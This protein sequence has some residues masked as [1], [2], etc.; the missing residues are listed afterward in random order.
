MHINLYGLKGLVS[1]LDGFE[2]SAEIS[3][4]RKRGWIDT[5]LRLLFL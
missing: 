1:Y 4:N 2:P 3:I 5:S